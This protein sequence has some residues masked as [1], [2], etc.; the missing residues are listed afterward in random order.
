MLMVCFVGIVMA[1]MVYYLADIGR[2]SA[3]SVGLDT[4]RVMAAATAEFAASLAVSKLTDLQFT[5]D[6]KRIKADWVTQDP[7]ENTFK[8]QRRFSGESNG[9][10]Y[11][12]TVRS[13][14][15]ARNNPTIPG[16]WLS[17]IEPLNFKFDP[18]DG[19]GDAAGDF[20]GVYEITAAAST[21]S[22]L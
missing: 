8:D 6:G 19:S 3:K 7:F 12:V 17:G 4:D 13:L 10:A 5:S 1:G 2:T 20:S 11:I 15:S 14:Q 9:Y 18:G 21:Q 22:I 16:S